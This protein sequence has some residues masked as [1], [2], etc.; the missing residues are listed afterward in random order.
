MFLSGC[1][2]VTAW[3]PS[4]GDPNQSNYIVQAQV[5]AQQIRCDQPQAPQVAGVAQYLNLFMS[6]STARGVLQQDV[7]RVVEPIQATVKE[8]QDRGE[9]SATYCRIKRELL[10]ATTGRAAQVVLG[11]W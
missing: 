5:A 10:V 4:F 1:A 9:G 6:Y 2:T 7:I 3:I 8:W 11:R